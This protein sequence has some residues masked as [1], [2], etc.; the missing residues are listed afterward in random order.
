MKNNKIRLVRD[1]L[2]EIDD[3]QFV[4]LLNLIN[5]LYIIAVCAFKFE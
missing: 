2:V 5:Y 3:V 4:Y 1:Y